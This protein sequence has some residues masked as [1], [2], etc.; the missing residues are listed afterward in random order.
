MATPATDFGRDRLRAVIREFG[1]A[2]RE[3]MVLAASRPGFRLR[4]R[5]TPDKPADAPGDTETVSLV[6]PTDLRDSLIA[7][8]E[9]PFHALVLAPTGAVRSWGFNKYGQLGDGTRTDRTELTDVQG[10]SEAVVAIAVATFQSCAVRDDGTVWQM[11]DAGARAD[12]RSRAGPRF[13]GRH[14]ARGTEAG[15]H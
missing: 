3:E 10:L 15:R 8:A 13:R 9:G 7:V 11:G 2:H 4:T 6:L 5:V 12:D 1:L 14:G